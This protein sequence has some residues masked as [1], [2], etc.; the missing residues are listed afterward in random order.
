MERRPATI[1]L[2]VSCFKNLSVSIEYLLHR[3]N[4]SSIVRIPREWTYDG[5]KREIG[6]PASSPVRPAPRK[7]WG[8]QW[9]I[10]SAVYARAPQSAKPLTASSTV[11]SACASTGK[12]SACVQP[13]FATRSPTQFFRR[14]GKGVDFERSLH[15]TTGRHAV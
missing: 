7:K 6:G 1:G 11:S 2:S 9:I 14:I 5:R 3:F 13:R 4:P 10:S 12:R 8:F 15:P